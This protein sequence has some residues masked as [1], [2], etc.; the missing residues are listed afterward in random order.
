[1]SSNHL[2]RCEIVGD[3]ATSVRARRYPSSMTTQFLRYACV[4][5]VGTAAHYFRADRAGA[6]CR[7]RARSGVDRGSHRRSVRQ[8]CTQ[9]PVHVCERPGA[10][11]RVAALS[12]HCRD[13]RRAERGCDGGDA[14]RGVAR[15][16]S[17][18]RW[19]QPVSCSSPDSS[20]T[21]D[22]RSEHAIASAPG[23]WRR[24]AIRCRW[25]FPSTT[26][27]RSWSS[28]TAG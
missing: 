16:T 18:L 6:G 3:T 8:L 27:R 22:G 14:R 9:P 2:S 28:S 13:G 23:G 12:G 4:G 17:W 21:A 24:G 10:P 20:L 7:R 15:I 26:R 25:S 19:W 5:A 1:M 11:D